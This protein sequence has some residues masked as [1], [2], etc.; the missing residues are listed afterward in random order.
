MPFEILKRIRDCE[1]DV[2]PCVQSQQDRDILLAIGAAQQRGQHV[3]LKQLEIMNLASLATV[4]R[5][6]TRL[7]KL[8]CIDKVVHSN[9]RR[10]TGFVVS[11]RLLPRLNKL[12]LVLKTI[13]QEVAMAEAAKPS[14]GNAA[15]VGSAANCADFF[16]NLRGKMSK[17]GEVKAL[18]CSYSAESD[19][20]LFVMMKVDGDP[21]GAANAVGGLVFGYDLVCASFRVPPGFHCDHAPK[22]ATCLGVRK[23]P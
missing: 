19:P 3:S 10:V 6:L 9:D 2:M 12:R 23:A 1:K 13:A 18:A 15:L 14:R 22:G 4:R 5:R 16:Q 7:V 8:G 17:Y 20:I 21:Q 11:R